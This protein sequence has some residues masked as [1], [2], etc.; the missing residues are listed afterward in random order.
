MNR[1]KKNQQGLISLNDLFWA[2]NELIG[3]QQNYLQSIA[4]LLKADLELKKI[5]NNLSN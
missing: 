2:Q 1:E 4:D 5:T 3:Q